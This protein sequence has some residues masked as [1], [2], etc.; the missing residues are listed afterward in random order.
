M[1][2]TDR[3]AYYIPCILQQGIYAVHL[4]SKVVQSCSLAFELNGARDKPLSCSVVKPEIHMNTIEHFETGGSHRELGL[5]IGSHFA[6][7]IHRFFDSYER[8]QRQLLPFYRTSTG[9]SYYQSFLALH[10]SRFPAY[11]SELEGIAEGA[12]RPFEEVFLVNLRGEFTGLIPPADQT[13]DAPVQGCTDCLVLTA[14]RALIGHNED[15]SPASLGHMYVVTVNPEDGPAFSALSYPGFLPG[16]AFGFNR[17]GI[18]LTVNHVAP[19]PIQL[20]ASRHFLARSLLDTRS[21]DEAIENITGP[22]RASGFNYNIGS[23]S[24]RRVVSVEVAPQRHHI[25]EIQGFYAHT[26]HY[27]E[28]TEQRQ[29]ISASSRQRLERSLALGRTTPP[30]EA[31][32]VLALLGNQSDRDYPIYRDATLPDADATLCSALYDLDGRELRIYSDHPVKAAEKY[33]KF[34]L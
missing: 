31:G 11:M 8:L 12:K 32:Q 23:L 10:R 24:E 16:N 14:D 21:L 9:K 28:L 34:C 2:D 27:F 19:R 13:D 22:D 3:S 17:T 6:D 33:L 20:G 26:N 5:A 18:L 7:A 30:G 15:G 1:L 25:R 4:R 29:E